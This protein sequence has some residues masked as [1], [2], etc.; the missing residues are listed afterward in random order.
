MSKADMA[1]YP[2]M[3]GAKKFVGEFK[4]N[5][6]A[7]SN[8]D[9]VVERAVERIKE[10]IRQDKD[11][12]K[13]EIKDATAEIL[14]FPIAM[15]ITKKAEESYLQK[16]FALIEAKK[17]SL[18]LE[19]EKEEKI[20]EIAREDFNWKIATANLNHLDRF[21][22]HFTDYLRNASVLHAEEWKLVNKTLSKGDVYLTKKEVVRLLQ[23]E[24]R[25]HIEEVFES[26]VLPK[27]PD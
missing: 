3:E 19:Q 2:F 24:V 27:L 13:G 23:E 22:L 17:I 12:F 15:I 5:E 6:F 4:I 18:N 25:H 9:C 8:Y 16:R 21:R 11:I 14:S 1:K 7:E 26:T 20:I 10:S